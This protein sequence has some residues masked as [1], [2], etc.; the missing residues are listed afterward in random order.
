M[1]APKKFNLYPPLLLLLI[2]GFLL[3]STWAAFQAAG[4]GSRVTDA[5]YYSKGLKYNSS[6]VEKRAAEILG[7]QLET[8]LAADR[9]NFHLT[10][11]EGKGVDQAN[12]SLYLAIPGKAENVHL[13]LQE[14]TAGHYQVELAAGL[15]GAI[16]ARLDLERG[17]ARLNRQILL[18]F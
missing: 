17:G 9:L 10:D 18:N 8:R 4:L 6:Q 7:W 3:F 15:T 1:T 14:I 2:S 5:A 16:Q 12:G 11:R 13:P